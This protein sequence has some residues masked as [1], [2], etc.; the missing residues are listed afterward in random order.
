MS[1]RCSVD[2][3]L[4]AE[5]VAIPVH[6]ALVCLGVGTRVGDKLLSSLQ[7]YGPVVAFK[8][9][10]CSNNVRIACVLCISHSQDVIS[11]YWNIIGKSS[12]YSSDGLLSFT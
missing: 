9:H 8:R 11:P 4:V 5:G 3:D 6:T 1:L 12:L 7:G 10:L 2:S